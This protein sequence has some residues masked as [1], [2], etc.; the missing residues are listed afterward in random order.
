MGKATSFD[1]TR[2]R[3]IK[4]KPAA[5]KQNLRNQ[6]RVD[7]SAEITVEKTDGC[8]LTCKVSNLSR[9][10]VMISCDQNIVQQLIPG[11]RAPAPGHW[12]EVKTRFTVPVL[13][14]QPVTVLADG[15][16]VHMRRISRNEFQVGIQFSEFEGNGFDYVDQYVAKLLADARKAIQD[17]H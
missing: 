12:I 7:V 2:A 15:N 13:P 11:L 16:I 8:C 10:G 3:K 6:Q 5:A 17:A 9:S 14:T 1:T 4:M